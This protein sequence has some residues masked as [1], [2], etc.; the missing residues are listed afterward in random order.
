MLPDDAFRRAFD[1]MA[2]DLVAWTGS[3]SDVASVECEA[4]GDAVRLSLKP[5]ASTACAL[6]FMLHRPSQ[7]YDVQFANSDMWEDIPV[8]GAPQALMPVLQAV[9]DGQILTRELISSATGKHRDRGVIVT[10]PSSPPRTYGLS[11]YRDDASLV[12]DRHWAPYRRT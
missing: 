8:V 9:T 2:K 10:P 7:S 6:E 5:H 12:K 1:E 11:G 3:Y 4:S